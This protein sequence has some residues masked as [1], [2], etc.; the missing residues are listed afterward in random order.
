V[1]SGNPLRT[2]SGTLTGQ[3]GSILWPRAKS[4]YLEPVPPD[5][6]GKTVLDAGYNCGFFSFEFAGRPGLPVAT[7]RLAASTKPL[8]SRA[9]S[10]A[11]KRQRLHA[12]K[13][14]EIT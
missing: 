4:C 14:T 8:I 3:Q 9:R 12:V 5:L 6:I 1:D 2:L 13:R 11:R 7:S 10:G